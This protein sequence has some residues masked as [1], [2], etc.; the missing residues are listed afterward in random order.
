VAATAGGNLLVLSS[1]ATID[2]TSLYS[3]ETPST[4][5]MAN[6]RT[7]QTGKYLG[8]KFYN[9]GTAATNYGW[10][11]VDTVSPTTGLPATIQSWCYQD[12]GTGITAGATTPVELET[13]T[14]D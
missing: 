4:A 14:V 2:A 12:N 8:V 10:I 7:T 13:F 1:G 9:E 5:A 6:W 11:Q 3:T